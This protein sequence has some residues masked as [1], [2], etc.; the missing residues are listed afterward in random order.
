MLSIETAERK[1]LLVTRHNEY[2]MAALRAKHRGDIEKAKEYMKICM[3]C[4]IHCI[5]I[6]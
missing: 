1:T 3:V 5:I 4:A 2:K 6:L